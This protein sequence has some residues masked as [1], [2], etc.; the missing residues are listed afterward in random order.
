MLRPNQEELR[1]L[2]RFFSTAASTTGVYNFQSKSVNTKHPLF[3][4]NLKTLR[5]LIKKQI[6]LRLLEQH[7][8]QCYNT[9]TKHTNIKSLAADLIDKAKTDVLAKNLI[10][11]TTLRIHRLLKDTKLPITRLN[12]GSDVTTQPDAEPLTLVEKTSFTLDELTR[13]FCSSFE[14]HYT[15]PRARSFAG[16]FNYL[17]G[18]YDLNTILFAIDITAETKMISGPLALMQY[19][20][21]AE[22]EVNS[23]KARR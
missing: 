23:R 2:S 13:F 22:D 21:D 9:K 17:L 15:K 11:P 18:I 10:S 6:D 19:A 4:A 7:C 14:I 12:Y 3:Q 1:I 16:A 5:Y 8:Q 20:S